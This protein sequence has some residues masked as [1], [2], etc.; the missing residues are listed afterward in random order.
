MENGQFGGLDFGT[1][2]ARISVINSRKELKYFNSVQYEY[3]F[4][5]PKSWI[6]SCEKLLHILPLDI[7]KENY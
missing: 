6:N 2:C 5:N 3:D 1:S 4:K 7:K